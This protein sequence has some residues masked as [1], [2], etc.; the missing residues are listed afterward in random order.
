MVELLVV[1]FILLVLAV[2]GT[3][4]L[5]A[6]KRQ[7][8]QSAS[9]DIKVL[10]QR[11]YSEAQRRGMAVFVQVGPRVTVGAS[12]S[13][14]IYLIGDRTQ[15]E[16]LDPFQK[17]PLAGED[18]LIDQYNIVV[19]GGVNQEFCL[20]DTN[21][22][23]VMS[24]L[25][26]DNTT[27]WNVARVIM[28][29]LQGRAMAVGPKPAAPKAGLPAS[30]GRQIGAPATLVL[31]HVDVVNGSLMPPTRYMLSINPVWSVRV[32]KQIKDSTPAWVDQ[33]G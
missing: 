21:T 14:P 27:P 15:D 19:T 9:G 28:C 33:N 3:G 5:P 18:I 25:W 2:V 30:T 8:L 13:V 23:Q 12:S 17:V 32:I 11:A 24:T 10:F 16:V 1:I 31:T 26:S 4:I 20:S 7:K 29:D 22:S 6:W